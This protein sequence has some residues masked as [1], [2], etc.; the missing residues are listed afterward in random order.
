[1]RDPVQTEAE[2][3]NLSPVQGVDWQKFEF[4]EGEVNL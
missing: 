1:M 4:E 3:K 2:I